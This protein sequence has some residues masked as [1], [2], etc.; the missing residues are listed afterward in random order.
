MAFCVEGCCSIAEGS[1]EA[2]DSA[3]FAALSIVAELDGSDSGGD[4]SS[5]ED[6][7]AFCKIYNQNLRN[8]KRL[9]Q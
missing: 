4:G 8:S 5:E 6:S 1:E 2:A 9:K 7:D 3:S